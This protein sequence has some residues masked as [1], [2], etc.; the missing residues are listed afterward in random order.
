MT[1]NSNYDKSDEILAN[2]I[3][4]WFDFG[5]ALKNRE[6]TVFFKMLE[7]CKIYESAARCKGELFSTESL[8]M[9]IIFNQQKLIKELIESSQQK[10]L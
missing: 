1:S 4:T 3:K 8:I 9:A 7:E 2:E 10:P 5:D 6:G